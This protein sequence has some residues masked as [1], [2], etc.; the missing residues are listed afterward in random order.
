MK[1]AIPSANP[2]AATT[3]PPLTAATATAGGV[4][5][6]KPPMAAPQPAIKGDIRSRLG[7]RPAGASA[8]EPAPKPAIQAEED[9]AGAFENRGFCFL[10]SNFASSESEVFCPY[11]EG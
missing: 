6:A 4:F 11:L 8:A 7:K 1:G 2:F 9:E 5:G 10:L 3:R